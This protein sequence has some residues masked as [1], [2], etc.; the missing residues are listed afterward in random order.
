MKHLAWALFLGALTGTGCVSSHEHMSTSKDTKE[1]R[2]DNVALPPPVTPGQINPD[3]AHAMSQA[4]WDEMERQ[5]QNVSVDGH[6]A[7]ATPA[8]KPK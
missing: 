4:L 8:A 1:V 3:N 2:R 6:S 5:A 7:A